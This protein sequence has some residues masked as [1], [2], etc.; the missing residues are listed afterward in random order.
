MHGQ[1]VLQYDYLWNSTQHIY[2]PYTE[3]MAFRLFAEN[4]CP[5]IWFVLKYT[6][7]WSLLTL[8]GHWFKIMA[9]C[10][11]GPWFNIKMSSHQYRKF[12]C[13]DKTVVRS[14]Y[15]HHGISYTGKMTSLYWFVPQMAINSPN[16][17]TTTTTTTTTTKLKQ[18]TKPQTP[19]P[20]KSYVIWGEAYFSA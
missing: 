8:P 19:N 17:T 6:S 3:N 4:I 7:L 2:H 1:Y 13:G 14:S 5:V 16:N 9:K 12:H 15:L 10:C 11:T 18:D 20:P